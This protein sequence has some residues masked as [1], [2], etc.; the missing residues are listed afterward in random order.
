M[1]ETAPLPPTAALAW[2]L[3]YRDPGAARDC[4]RALVHE[5]GAAATQ[6]WLVLALYDARLGD[7]DDVLTALEKRQPGETVT[8]S[9]WRDGKTRKQSVVLGAAD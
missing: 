6:G 2:E 1:S 5:G 7:L 3:S 9:L 8:L 4:A